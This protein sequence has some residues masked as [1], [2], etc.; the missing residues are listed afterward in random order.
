MCRNYGL[1]SSRT[2]QASMFSITPN[3]R[4]LSTWAS[5]LLLLALAGCQK[6]DPIVTY[7]IPTK[8]PAQMRPA[9][10]RMLAAMVPLGDQIWFFKVTGPETAIASIEERFKEF[11]S[12][13]KFEDGKPKLDELPEGWQRAGE[14]AMR[15]ASI[16]ITTPEK[17]LDLSVSSLP[18]SGDWDEQVL[19]NV[20]RWRGQLG[21]DPSTQKWAEGM[22]LE[23]PSADGDSVWVDLVGDSSKAS[24]MSASPPFASGAPFAAM[25]RELTESPSPVASTTP[26]EPSGEPPFKYD[27]P[28]GWRSGKMS[29]MRWAAFNVG[30]DDAMAELTV[31][32]AGGDLRAN[33]ARWIGQVRSSGAPDEIVDKALEDA[34]KIEVDGRASQRFLLLGED[35]ENGTAIDATIVPL[36]DGMSLSVKMTGPSKTVRDAS[37]QIADFLKSIKL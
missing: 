9:N 32:P 23:V 34:Q 36:E 28:E 37:D 6:A 31:M 35:A 13:A 3:T 27:T 25:P 22:P 17:Q 30:P 20:N 5:T 2:Y 18:K 1:D 15:F 12:D 8:M 19:A 16:D 4:V 26:T 7:T 33:V 24:S 10:E 14:K 21:L 11:V 29:M